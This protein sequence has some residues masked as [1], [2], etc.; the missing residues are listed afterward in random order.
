MYISGLYGREGKV[1]TALC[2]RKLCENAC[3]LF[4]TIRACV[5]CNLAGGLMAG[6]V[7]VVCFAIWISVSFGARAFPVIYF[8]VRYALC[9]Y[10]ISD[11]ETDD[12]RRVAG[13][14]EPLG[15]TARTPLDL[16]GVPEQVLPRRRCD[17]PPCKARHMCTGWVLQ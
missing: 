2:C 1:C 8:C 10:E 17:H 12:H 13:D 15:H 6:L 3:R 9:V 11:R 7:L 4:V 5:I 16:G 14:G